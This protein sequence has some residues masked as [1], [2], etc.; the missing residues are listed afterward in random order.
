MA[1]SDDNY[2]PQN[3]FHSLLFLQPVVI[4]FVNFCAQRFNYWYFTTNGQPHW[5]PPN[6]SYY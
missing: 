6:C 3:N 5:N 2:S 1:Y 4:K